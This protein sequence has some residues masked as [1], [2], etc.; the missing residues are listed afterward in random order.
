MELSHPPAKPFLVAY[1]YGVGGLWAIIHADSAEAIRERYLELGI[2]D[3]RPP[4]MTDERFAELP[5]YD[6]DAPPPG[7]PLAVLADRE[8]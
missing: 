5:R 2:A 4:W 3:S 1:E 6:L 7:V 8:T